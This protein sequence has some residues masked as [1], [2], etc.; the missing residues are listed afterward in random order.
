MNNISHITYLQ[1]ILCFV[2]LIMFMSRME[3]L[4]QNEMNALQSIV[5]NCIN[6]IRR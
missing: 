1:R 3:Y 6:I 2:H 4:Y 5:A